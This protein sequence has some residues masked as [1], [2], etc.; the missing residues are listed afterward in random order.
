[1]PLQSPRRCF[2]KYL[3]IASWDGQTPFHRAGVARSSAFG[4][5]LAGGFP[6]EACVHAVTS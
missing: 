4:K 2:R 1:M 3:A 6:V 5:P